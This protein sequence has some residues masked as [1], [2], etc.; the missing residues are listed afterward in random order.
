[1][2]TLPAL[3]T[4]NVGKM[5]LSPQKRGRQAFKRLCSHHL[6]TLPASPRRGGLTFK[7]LGLQ[8]FF[9]LPTELLTGF[10]PLEYKGGKTFKRHCLKR[11]DTMEA[12][13]DYRSIRDFIR[14]GLQTPLPGW[15][16]FISPRKHS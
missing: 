9:T 13:P 6:T 1:M 4:T 8:D 11:I 16:Y 14:G 3:P 10:T 15:E 5:P 12:L 2:T 7:T